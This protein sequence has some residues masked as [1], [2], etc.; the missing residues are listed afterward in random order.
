MGL[1]FPVCLIYAP[2][3][4]TFIQ[5]NKDE[6]KK[7]ELILVSAKAFII[8]SSLRYGKALQRDNVKVHALKSLSRSQPF[9][10]GAAKQIYDKIPAS[11]LLCFR[12][13]WLI[14]VEAW[15]APVIP[16]AHWFCVDSLT[17]CIFVCL[18]LMDSLPA[19]S[20]SAQ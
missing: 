3:T 1:I 4:R 11:S 17:R 15:V 13:L 9:V 7:I 10:L 5:G 12:P 20:S 6:K 18:L 8:Q 14:A 2:V 19:G 16:G